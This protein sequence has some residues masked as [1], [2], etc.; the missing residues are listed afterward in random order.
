[1]QDAIAALVAVLIVLQIKHSLCDYPFQTLFMLRNKGTYFH[2]GGIV[3]AGLHAVCTM[4]AFFVV[5]PTLLL[6]A[7]IIV[8]EFLVHYHVDWTK[9]QIIRRKGWTPAQREF[10]WAIGADQLLHHLTYIGIAAL[11]VTEMIK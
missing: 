4:A 6:G 10:W 2:L 5:A 8:G 1:V 3:H 7:A 9:E 11:L